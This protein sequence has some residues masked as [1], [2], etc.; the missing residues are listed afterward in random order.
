[1][2]EMTAR[3]CHPR[4]SNRGSRARNCSR[5]LPAYYRGNDKRRRIPFLKHHIAIRRR[6]LRLAYARLTGGTADLLT[7]HIDKMLHIISSSAKEGCYSLP[8]G[9]RFVRKG[10]SIQ[11]R[12]SAH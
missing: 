4:G 10:D 9:V 12:R 11:L 7:D 3:F 1:L 2:D 6:L 8:R 5:E